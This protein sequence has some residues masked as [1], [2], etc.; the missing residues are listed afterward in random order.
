MAGKL[1]LFVYDNT[2]FFS[3]THENHSQMQKINGN[4]TIHIQI[5]QRNSRA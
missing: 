2:V 4:A 5:K 3:E 1:I